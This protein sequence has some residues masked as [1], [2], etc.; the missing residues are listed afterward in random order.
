MWNDGREMSRE[1]FNIINS[2]LSWRIRIICKRSQK[3]NQKGIKLPGPLLIITSTVRASKMII[4]DESRSSCK[5]K[6]CHSISFSKFGLAARVLRWRRNAGQ[7]RNLG[8]PLNESIL[9]EYVHYLS[10]I[11]DVTDQERQVALVMANQK[12]FKKKP[13]TFII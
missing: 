6:R 1:L 4:P 10:G 7:H 12:L 2:E 11:A 13:S 5:Y 9:L 3:P 8:F